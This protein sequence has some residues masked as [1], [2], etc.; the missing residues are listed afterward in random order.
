MPIYVGGSEVSKVYV[1]AT[2][3]SKV[4]VGSTEVWSAVPPTRDILIVNGLNNGPVF[5][6]DATSWDSGLPVP[7][8]ATAPQGVAF[9]RL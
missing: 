4:Y 9:D 6:H 7:T 5:R 1:G 2:A 3:L 8:A